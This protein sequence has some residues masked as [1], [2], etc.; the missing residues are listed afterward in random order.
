[1]AKSTLN[2]NPI[3]FKQKGNK[4]LEELMKKHPNVIDPNSK[5]QKFKKRIN[6][7]CKYMFF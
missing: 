4:R 6:F 1:M 3:F 2:L 5:F 7:K